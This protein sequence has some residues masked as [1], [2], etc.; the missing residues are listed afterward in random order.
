MK[1]ILRNNV[2]QC[3]TP[4]RAR[5]SQAAL[6]PGLSA[7][8]Q[9]PGWNCKCLAARPSWKF[10]PGARLLGIGRKTGGSGGT[11]QESEVFQQEKG[12]PAEIVSDWKPMT[13]LIFSLGDFFWN[14]EKNTHLSN[15]WI[16]RS[17]SSSVWDSI[18][19]FMALS[20]HRGMDW[21]SLRF[22][23]DHTSMAASPSDLS[24]SSS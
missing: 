7:E 22:M 10:F 17:A 18:A 9:N 3:F 1:Y 24:C 12:N 20:F 16:L 11:G 4:W 15:S 13:V 23:T 19:A 2:S 21:D 14:A 8:K 5:P 6:G